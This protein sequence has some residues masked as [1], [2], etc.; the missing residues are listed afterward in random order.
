M[1]KFTFECLFWK[2]LYSFQIN[3]HFYEQCSGMIYIP[4]DK[5]HFK[6]KE[7]T[8]PVRNLLDVLLLSKLNF[9]F[10][11]HRE[12]VLHQLHYFLDKPNII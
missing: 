10:S 6:Y 9:Y 3:A 1:C 7:L 4:R 2:H 11:E 5:K 12:L 8:W